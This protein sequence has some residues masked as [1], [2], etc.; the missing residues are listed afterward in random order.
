MP[1]Q[2]AYVI[3]TPYSLHKSRTGGI[4][5]RLITRTG[6]ELVAAR[7]FAPSAEL[8]KEYARETISADDPQDRNIQ[9]LIYDYILRNLAPDPK[10][11][12]RRRVMVL[13][14]QG[15]DAVSKTRAVVGNVCPDRRVGET[16]RDTYGDLITDEHD[17]LRYF[18]PAVLA[19]PTL[20]EAEK[21]LKLWA[22]YADTDGG[23]LKDVIVYQPGEKPQQTLVLIKP[24]NFRF[25]TGRPGNMI[26]FFSRTGLYIVGVKVHRMSVAQA[27]QFYGPVR[28]TLRTKLKDVVAAKAAAAL[29][30]EFGFAIAREQQEQLGALLGP[31]FG[32]NQFDNIVRFMSGRSPA[33]CPPGEEEKPGSEKCIALVYEGVGAVAKIRDVLGPTDPS[34]APPGSIRREFGQTIMVNAA[35]AS[36]SEENARR[37]MGIVNVAENNFRQVVEQFYGKT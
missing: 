23:V 15:E 14:F 12:R 21:K 5:T 31:S 26:D 33:E 6:C 19:A 35:H 17:Q 8:V 16:I 3:I 34:K 18:E 32:D 29:E 4:L 10:T 13:L 20:A 24:E 30:K 9:E 2:L 28:E 25:A 7:M 27:L 37:E 22:H 11:G 36:D 1:Q